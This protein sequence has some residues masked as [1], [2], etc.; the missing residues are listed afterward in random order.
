MGPQV[1][2]S[3]ETKAVAR[4]ILATAIEVVVERD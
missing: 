2:R 4:L 3:R 1:F